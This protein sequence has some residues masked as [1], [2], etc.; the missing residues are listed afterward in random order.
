MITIISATNRPH[1]NTLKVVKNYAK[2]L[3]KNGENAKIFSLEDLPPDFIVTDLYSNRSQKFAHILDEF[4]VNSEKFVIISPEYNGSYPGIL[5]TFIDS[6]NPEI[7][8]EKKVALVGVSSGRAGNVVGL[9]QL[10]TILHHLGMH[11]HFNKLPISN[12]LTLLDENGNLKD[13]NTIKV[14]EKQIDQ[15][16]KY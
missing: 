2:L 10:T 1:S 3:D 4:I 9:D 15:F 12:I 7:L 11:V 6:F 5:K 8:R 16:L 13:L 14:L